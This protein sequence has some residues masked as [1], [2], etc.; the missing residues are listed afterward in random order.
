LLVFPLDG[1]SVVEAKASR[2][3]VLK[4]L[5]PSREI[6]LVK[7]FFSET[8]DENSEDREVAASHATA[9]LFI[10]SWVFVQ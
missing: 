7:Y 3:L 8:N 9:A 10:S 1:G 5:R 2:N 4:V 6:D